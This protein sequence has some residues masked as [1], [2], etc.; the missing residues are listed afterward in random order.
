MDPI[1][2]I[3][4]PMVFYT[5]FV[6]PFLRTKDAYRTYVPALMSGVT[7]VQD[8]SIKTGKKPVENPLFG[9]KPTQQAAQQQTAPKAL[10]PIDIMK[11]N[12]ANRGLK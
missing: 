7:K 6:K 9:P 11:Q 3:R 4:N 1:E 10:S 8:A 2:L 12:A 5:K